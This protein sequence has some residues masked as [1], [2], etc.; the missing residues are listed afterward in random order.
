MVSPDGQIYDR[1][2]DE[3]FQ[4]YYDFISGSSRCHCKR[5]C[6]RHRISTKWHWEMTESGHI[7]NLLVTSVCNWSGPGFEH[8]GSNGYLKTEKSGDPFLNIEL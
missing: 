7:I 5:P 6:V 4:T 8:G 2:T 1:G 3:V